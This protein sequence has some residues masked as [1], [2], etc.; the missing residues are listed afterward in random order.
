MMKNVSKIFLVLLIALTVFSLTSCS[1]DS[2]DVN[3]GTEVENGTLEK[4]TIVFGVTPWTSTI[5]P[6]NVAKLLI[7]EMGYT[8]ELQDADAGVVYA[9]LSKGDVDVYM[10]AWLPDLHANYMA[11]YGEKIEDVSVSYPDGETGWVVPS[12]VDSINT[13]EDIIGN[14]DLFEGEVIGI[15][16]GA[17]MT[18]SS[19][20]MIEELDLDLE[21]IASSEAAMLAQVS[22][23]IANEE[24]VIFLGW[25]P[26]SMF[27][28]WDLKI[29]PNSAGY[30]A[31]SEVHVLVSNVSE[32]ST[33]APDVY[34]F[35]SNWSMPVGDIEDMILE[36]DNGADAEEVAQKWIDNNQDKVNAMLNK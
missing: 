31:T 15:D 18:A 13:V 10:D 14:E 16:E 6:T 30:F 12:Y 33:T 29:I 17:G 7:E 26:H 22:K 19:R 24:P 34:E 2:N 5:P 8:V 35:L 25:R 1:N 4:E 36:I 23:S 20:E 32:L 9:G 28:M 11:E 27:A 21:Y 3:N